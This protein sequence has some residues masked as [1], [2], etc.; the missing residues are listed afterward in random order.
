MDVDYRY[1]EQGGESI[2]SS[3]RAPSPHHTSVVN[4]GPR[5]FLHDHRR[6]RRDSFNLEVLVQSEVRDAHR[7]LELVKEVCE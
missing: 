5:A 7:G 4:G 3:S 6:A 1:R 2:Y